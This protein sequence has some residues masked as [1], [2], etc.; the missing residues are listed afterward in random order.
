MRNAFPFAQASLFLFIL[1]SF[2][3]TKNEIEN[4]GSSLAMNRSTPKSALASE[5]QTIHVFAFNI[6]APCWADPGYYPKSSAS[7]LNRLDR[8][9]AIIELLKSYQDKVDIFMLQEVA[10][11]E[12][13]FINEVLK[14]THAGF[15]AN[16]A[17][18]YWS[19]WITPLTPWEV[20]GNALFVSKTRFSSIDFED[21]AASSSGNHAALF[22]GLIN[23]SGGRMIRAASIHLDSDHAY[24]RKRELQAV[25][26]KWPVGNNNYTDI[27]AGDFNTETNA[28][29]IQSD[30]KEA[31]F[32][33]V[34]T[35][36]GKARQT[37]PWNSKYYRSDNWGII[38]HIIS[39]NSTPIDGSVLDSQLFE[40]YP[41]NEE[42]RINMN[43]QLTGSDHF[44]VTGTI[45]R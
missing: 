30:I 19:N 29:N 26:G 40:L 9:Q 1:F 22:T 10:Q 28:T 35:V 32:Y 36:L 38:D 16:H 39:R 12:F 6:L 23:N 44:P 20:N 42:M 18:W 15:Q 34:L 3:C 17:S 11:A 21:F 8:R 14:S 7:F 37:H 5:D 41:K 31:G 43:L 25:L 33:D 4:R 45:A 27:I 2:S 24:N 13:D